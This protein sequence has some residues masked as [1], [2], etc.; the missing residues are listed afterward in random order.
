MFSP[1][2]PSLFVA[3]LCLLATAC[4]GRTGSAPTLPTGDRIAIMVLP[5]RGITPGM[6]PA[7][8]KQLNDLG[9]WMEGDL[10][11]ILNKTGYSATRSQDAS[12]HA[13]PGRYVLRIK[14]ANYDAGSKA[15]RLLVGF[16]AGTARLDTH[17]ELVGEGEGV[18]L[19]GDPSVASSRDWTNAAR[20]VNLNTVDSV[21]A[22][23]KHAR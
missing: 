17:F 22:Y 21:N 7:R 18:A 4:S 15:A 3:L 12:I 23:L 6:D 1:K 8:A 19:A 20:K 14:I 5:D 16:G 10:V 13:G 2:L 9:T 11:D